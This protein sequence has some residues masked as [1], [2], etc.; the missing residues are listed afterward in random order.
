MH[1]TERVES[2]LL[3]RCMGKARESFAKLASRILGV[4]GL[5]SGQWPLQM[6]VLPF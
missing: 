6:R 3:A 1:N 2:S 4:L 5:L